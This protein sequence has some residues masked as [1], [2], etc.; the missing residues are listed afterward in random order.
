MKLTRL[1]AVAVVGLALGACSADG[2][3]QAVP[4][5]AGSRVVTRYYWRTDSLR[6]LDCDVS[7]PQTLSIRVPVRNAS[8]APLQRAYRVLMD[9]GCA[10][11]A[12]L[13]E[14]GGHLFEVGDRCDF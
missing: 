11:Q 3:A 6:R 4:E 12:R 1:A 7:P 2:T 10:R 5:C 14:L 13:V 9:Y 8:D